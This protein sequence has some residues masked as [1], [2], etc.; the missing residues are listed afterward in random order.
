MMHRFE[1]TFFAALEHRPVDNPTRRPAVFDELQIRTELVAQRADRRIDDVGAI[2]SEEHDVA[3]DRR[4]T[5][6]HGFDHRRRQEL[7][8]RRL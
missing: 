5:I 7:Q 6:E 4:T 1:A 8:Y 3:G 2:G